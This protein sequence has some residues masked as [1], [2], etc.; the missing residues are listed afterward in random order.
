MRLNRQFRPCKNA[1]SR[2]RL[3]QMVIETGKPIASVAAQTGR[4]SHAR[5]ICRI[6][7]G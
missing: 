7:A 3:L 2:L 1:S 4:A 6:K 5:P